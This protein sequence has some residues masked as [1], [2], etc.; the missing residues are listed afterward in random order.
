MSHFKKYNSGLDISLEGIR[1]MLS[2]L[3]KTYEEKGKS[4]GTSYQYVQGVCSGVMKISPRKWATLNAKLLF[5]EDKIDVPKLKKSIFAS[6]INN[7]NIISVNSV[8]NCVVIF[9]T[10][11]KDYE[12]EKEILNHFGISGI[13][14]TYASGKFP[15]FISIN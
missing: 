4:L 12:R 3:G 7:K 2:I 5:P 1:N 8:G 14:V 10:E 6:P 11:V 9:S 13:I 15:K